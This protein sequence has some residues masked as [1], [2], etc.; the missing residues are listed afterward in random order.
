MREFCTDLCMKSFDLATRKVKIPKSVCDKMPGPISKGLCG[1][2]VNKANDILGDYIGDKVEDAC[3][4]LCQTILE[5]MGWLPL[6]DNIKASNE[7]TMCIQKHGEGDLGVCMPI[8][9]LSGRPM[10]P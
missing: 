6:F 8:C 9:K 1:W 7:C 4:C 3:D 10:E 5:D 2:V